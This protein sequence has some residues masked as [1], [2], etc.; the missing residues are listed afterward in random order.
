VERKKE[1]ERER[2]RERAL[3]IGEDLSQPAINSATALIMFPQ[4]FSLA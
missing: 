1:K 2:E 4:L 3:K